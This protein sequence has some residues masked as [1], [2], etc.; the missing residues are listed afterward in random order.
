MCNIN[1]YKKEHCS[2]FIVPYLL[3]IVKR[4][5]DLFYMYIV[6]ESISQR[7]YSQRAKFHA[8]IEKKALNLIKPHYHQPQRIPSK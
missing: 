2:L 1:T 7:K 6:Q 8:G 5:H 4:I 3:S